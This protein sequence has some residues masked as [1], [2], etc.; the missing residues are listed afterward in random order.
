[1][2]DDDNEKNSIKKRDFTEKTSSGV[3]SNTQNISNE[4][5][6]EQPLIHETVVIDD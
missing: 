3:V 1:M 4:N 5:L 6:E 2:N